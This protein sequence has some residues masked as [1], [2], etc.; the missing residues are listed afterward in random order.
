[1]IGA[2]GFGARSADGAASFGPGTLLELQ[3]R[4]EMHLRRA[5]QR[6]LPALAAPDWPTAVVAAASAL[7]AGR[8]HVA[9]AQRLIAEVLATTLP[10]PVH[11]FVVS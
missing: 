3:A 11:V 1:M 6:A 8:S 9:A 7:V 10:A 2:D 5:I 4:A